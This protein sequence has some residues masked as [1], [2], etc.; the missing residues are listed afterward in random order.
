MLLLQFQIAYMTRALTP[1]IPKDQRSTLT[2]H[3]VQLS[4]A[5]TSCSFFRQSLEKCGAR[6][7]QMG[8]E[9]L[10]GTIAHLGGV[11][12]CRGRDIVY[13]TDV[14]YEI[15]FP[16]FIFYL[17]ITE[18]PFRKIE[19]AVIYNFLHYYIFTTLVH[20]TDVPNDSSF[21]LTHW[22]THAPANSCQQLSDISTTKSSLLY[23]SA[24][25]I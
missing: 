25:S 23:S 7:S 16:S 3:S 9:W 2:D 12:A 20:S 22:S 8:N 6:E 10:W 24:S 13:G 14:H 19:R 11:V 4:N 5:R 15:Q 21:S 1:P 18:S 17:C